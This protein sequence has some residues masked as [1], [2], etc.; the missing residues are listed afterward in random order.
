MSRPILQLVGDAASTVTQALAGN[1]SARASGALKNTTCFF[2]ILIPSLQVLT[3]MTPS[4]RW[5]S[6]A[7]P[8]LR[9]SVVISCPACG[10]I[11][12]LTQWR[13]KELWY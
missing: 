4:R 12:E 5:R 11:T 6:Q 13:G 8:S 1:E 9:R 10:S 2:A 7:L 3:E